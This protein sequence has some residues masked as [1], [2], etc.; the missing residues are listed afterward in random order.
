[1]QAVVQWLDSGDA[2]LQPLGCNESAADNGDGDDQGD[3]LDDQGGSG[4][5]GVGVADGLRA[6]LVAADAGQRLAA[7]CAQ[8]PGHSSVRQAVS[9]SQLQDTLQ[10]Q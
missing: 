10:V 6:Q 1:M 7:L 9:D 5:G 4:G 8:L 2:R 3:C